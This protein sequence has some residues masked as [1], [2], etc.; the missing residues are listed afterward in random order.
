MSTR[1][2]SV[3]SAPFDAEGILRSMRPLI[4]IPPCLDDRGRWRSGRAYHYMDAAYARALDAA[5]AHVLVLPA[6]ADPA[7][8]VARL[9][10]LTEFSLAQK[11]IQ[12]RVQPAQGQNQQAAVQ[13]VHP[14]RVQAGKHQ[15]QPNG[16]LLITDTKSGR[17][18]EINQQGEIV[19]QYINYVNQEYF[20]REVV[21][22]VS[23]VQR[24]PIEYTN[25]F[26]SEESD[27]TTSQSNS[28]V[29]KN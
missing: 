24:L 18:F 5:G 1:A 20:D 16:N 3:R 19:W 10:G 13:H 23:E 28:T 27:N 9:D 8:L 21:G 12:R 15:W 17:G 11:L 22:D 14:L 29:G 7:A 6:Q 4:G 25:I 26:S 2:I